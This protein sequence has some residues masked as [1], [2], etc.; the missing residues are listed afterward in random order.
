MKNSPKILKKTT[1]KQQHHQYIS[2][3]AINTANNKSKLINIKNSNHTALNSLLKKKNREQN[4]HKNKTR[5]ITEAARRR[6]T[7]FSHC[8]RIFSSFYFHA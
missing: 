4:K 8:F 6:S 5:K 7:C 2:A 1:K 3:L